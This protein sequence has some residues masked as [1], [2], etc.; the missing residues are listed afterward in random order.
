[1]A[2]PARATRSASVRDTRYHGRE[3]AYVRKGGAVSPTVVTL[4]SRASN[5]YTA[6]RRRQAIDEA[7]DGRLML[8]ADLW[9]ASLVE[10]GTSSGI[11]STISHGILG[12][13]LN[14]QGD[15]EQVSALVDCDNTPGDFG[16]M[17]PES[18]A[19]SV[20]L[21]GIGF[22]AGI[23]QMLE[24]KT[25]EVGDR[26]IPRMR[27]WDPRWLR[28]DPNSQAWYLMTRDGEVEIKPGDGEWVLFTPYGDVKSYTKAPW[29]FSTLA[30]V[31]ARDAAFDRQRHSEVCS[32]VRVMRADKPTTSQSR[33]KAKALL[34]R[35]QRDNRFVLPEQYKYELIESTGKIAD[36]YQAIIDWAGK[37]WAIGWTGQTVTTEGG[38]GF[39][40]EGTI[41]QRIARDKLRFYA[42]V[43][44][45]CLRTQYLT[46]WAWQNFGSCHPPTGGYNVDPPEDIA[47][48]GTARGQWAQGIIQMNAAAKEIGGKLNAQWVIEDAQKQGVVID[49]P[50]I[51]DLDDEGTENDLPTPGYAERCAAML[52]EEPAEERCRHGNPNSCRDC[53]VRREDIR[54][55]NA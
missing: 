1:M 17:F 22:G 46:H 3:S 52:N 43:W 25:R 27:W 39:V 45:E 19:A 15:P 51:P 47:A 34:E 11:A 12:L 7:H 8:G 36:I 21:D 44:F 16:L 49:M 2:K 26:L 55:K 23:G 6:K 41:H 4:P 42:K 48:K 32:P 20:F 40:T 50:D 29:I 35:M 38:K 10:F 14:L 9:R 33:A 31:F 53:G 18:E 30:F 5:E 28:Q 37:E 24:P 54:I 13:P